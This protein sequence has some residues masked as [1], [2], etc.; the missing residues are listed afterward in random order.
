MKK[1]LSL[2]LFLT[3][4]AAGTAAVSQGP[5]PTGAAALQACR[6]VLCPPRVEVAMQERCMSNQAEVYAALADAKARRAWLLQKGCPAS[7]ID[8]AAEAKP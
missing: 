8:A 1:T 4:C 7:V 2:I 6:D 5:A 3:G